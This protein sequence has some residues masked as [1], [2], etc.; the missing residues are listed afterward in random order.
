MKARIKSFTTR[1]Q[2]EEEHAKIKQN[3]GDCWK[4]KGWDFWTQAE[5]S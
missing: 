4:V 3:R 1:E 5:A 2:A